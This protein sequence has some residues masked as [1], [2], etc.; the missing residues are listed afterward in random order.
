M[1][2]S[3]SQGDREHMKERL[4]SSGRKRNDYGKFHGLLLNKKSQHL[5]AS[6]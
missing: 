4:H 6:R 3:I 1:A 5:L 2:K